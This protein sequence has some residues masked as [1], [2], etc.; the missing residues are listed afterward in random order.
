MSHRQKT[1]VRILTAL[2]TAAIGVLALS[3]PAAAQVS[4][5]PD[6]TSGGGTQTFAF[7]LANER[8]DTKSTR[9]EL[10]FPQDPPIAFVQV[11][12]V[13]GW[14]ATVHSRPLNPP[15][16][17][18]D[19]TVSEVAASLVLEGGAVPPGQF[20]QFIVTLGPLPATGRLVF[21]A[22]QGFANGAV[23]HWTDTPGQNSPAP[24]ITLGQ[25]VAAAP[26]A[27]SA[28]TGA[29]PQ[30]DVTSSVPTY[31]A[32]T[33]RAESGGGPP[34]ALLWGALGLAAVIIAI[35]WHRARRRRKGLADPE[36]DLFD[37]PEYMDEAEVNS[38]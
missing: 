18:G 30:Q 12:P 24:V 6:Q 37:E 20:E 29:A 25:P 1:F 11:T 3:A 31:Q 35:V 17:V 27:T 7:R 13:P 33:P 4:I 26:A 15:V 22:T 21:Q 28:P 9:L 32:D 16:E 5:V 19:R 14:T 34:L 10:D 2:C 38:P 36:N 23:A 8:T